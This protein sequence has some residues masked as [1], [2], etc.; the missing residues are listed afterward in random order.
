[1]EKEV[2]E[3]IKEV[4]TQKVVV[5]FVENEGKIEN[6]ELQHL[7]KYSKVVK[8]FNSLN[9]SIISLYSK[10]VKALTEV[11]DILKSSQQISPAIN[12]S[13]Y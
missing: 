5:H 11:S 12:L 3:L 9:P 4:A 13:N 7:L 2:A 8:A 6:D 10:D 1:D